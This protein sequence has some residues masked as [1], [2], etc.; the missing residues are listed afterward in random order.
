MTTDMPTIA[1]HTLG[2]KVNQYETEKIRQSL[3][4]MGFTTVP[5]S[6]RADAYII[7]TC[8]V[9]AVADAKSRA[10]VRKALRS[11]PE[12]FVV[13]AG[14]YAELGPAKI[15][16][17]EGVD[18]IVAHKDKNDIP[19]R[20]AAHFGISEKSAS[21]SELHPRPRSRTRAVVK[22][23]D[24]CDNF[25]SYCVIPYARVGMTSRQVGD[26]IDELKSLADFGYKEIVL[27][28]I[29][30]G[31][32]ED[33]GLNLP[34]LIIRAAD[35]DGIE[36]IRL[37]SIEPWEVNDHL[38]DV[39]NHPKVCKHL[40]IPLQS[41]DSRVLTCMNRPY[42]AD[43]YKQ[44]ITRV[45]ERIEDIGITTDVIVGF[46]GE[47]DDEFANTCSL[48][49]AVGFSR[50]HVFRYSR[51][52]GTKA[53]NMP[54]QIDSDTRKARAEKLT[55]I[56]RSTMHKFAVAHVGKFMDVLVETGAPIVSSY[57][58]RYDG[59]QARLVGFTGNYIS[60]TFTGDIFLKGNIVKVKIVD[61]DSDGC[62]VGSLG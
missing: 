26:V 18:L 13:V 59:E 50:L 56:G 25:C 44:I 12:A 19:E 20:L 36:R 15:S 5:F 49:D 2:C 33:K 23:Q 42:D 61:T 58:N 48:I 21:E 11:N 24:G 43:E 28:G 17:I 57:D 60:V 37:S 30:L 4:S 46:P 32:Y 14:C 51:R 16:S 47:S 53:A 41:G 34:E 55:E 10:A 3:E 40:H 1:Y 45:R 9:T 39:M 22:V 35:I 62:V 31:S 54:D 7:N 8:S 52:P 27:A 38:L 29:R 6:A